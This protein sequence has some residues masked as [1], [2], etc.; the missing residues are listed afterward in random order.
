MITLRR[1]KDRRHEQRRKQEVWRTFHRQAGTDPFADGFGTLEL[2]NEDRHPP[3]AGV[4]RRHLHDAEIITYVREGALAYEDSTGCAGIIQAGEFHRMTA[5]RGVRYSEANASRADWAQTFQIWL[6]PSETGVELGHEQRRFSTAQRRGELCIVASPDARR[7]SLR[8]RQNA[9]MYSAMLS[10]GKHVV[11]ELAEGRSAWLHLVKGEMTCGDFIL[12][13]GDGAGVTAERA[14]SL[15]AREE[16]EILL[17]DLGDRSPRPHTN[18]GVPVNNPEF[19][20]PDAV[21]PRL[22]TPPTG[23]QGLAG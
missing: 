7:G 1:A 14:V 3:G 18:G 11:H 19:L 5:A 10:P 6:Y 9:L 21:R 16:T 20:A 15:T 13:T 17:L 8:L 22:P 2:F 12:S 23:R 4:R